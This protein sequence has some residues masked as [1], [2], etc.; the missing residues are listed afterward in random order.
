[1][2]CKEA[3]LKR[4]I[5]EI[6]DESSA[7]YDSCHG[8]GIKTEEEHEAWI[9]V[10]EKVVPSKSTKV[11]DVGC[12]TGAMSLLLAEM[13]HQ[14]T[15]VDLS[16]KML[17]KAR[18]KAK[19]DKLK[20]RFERGD[21]EALVFKDKSFGLVINRHLLWTLPNPGAALNEWRRV[22]MDNGRAVVIDGLWNDGSINHRVRR[23]ISDFFIVVQERRNPRK[24]WYEKEVDCFL[25]H[26]R[27]MS[28]DRA[29]DYFDGA[30]FVDL[31]LT[32][33][34]DIRGIQKR[35]MPISQKITYDF[36]YYM[37]SGMK[38]PEANAS[39]ACAPR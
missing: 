26:P 19:A 38:A 24:G 11:L 32:V 31:D 18:I 33:L 23:L 13:G 36:V 14:V 16:E 3:G 39:K 4:A 25:P 35:H 9:K 22:L 34:N 1:M 27:G 15:G 7:R 20:V 6:W 37:V 28:M 10:L 21:A 5:Q 29:R 17:A 2:S 8:H 30:G 12:G